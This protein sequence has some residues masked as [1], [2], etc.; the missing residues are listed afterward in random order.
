VSSF[1]LGHWVGTVDFPV[2]QSLDNFLL[3]LARV[4]IIVHWYISSLQLGNSGLN[5]CGSRGC[6]GVLQV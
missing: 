1:L 2:V 5:L 4:I 3:L 6:V